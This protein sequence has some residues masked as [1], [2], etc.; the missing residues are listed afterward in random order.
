MSLLPY[1]CAQIL[2]L[3]PYFYSSPILSSFPYL[4]FS[5]PI[6]VNYFSP[7]V[8]NDHKGSIFRQVKIINV[9]RWGKNHFPKFGSI[10]NTCQRYLTWFDPRT[11]FF[12]PRLKG[13]NDHVE[14]NTYSSFSRSNTRIATSQT[15]HM[16]PLDQ[17]SIEAIVVPYK[18]QIHFIFMNE[19]IRHEE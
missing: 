2:I 12:T 14:L 3:S 17:V 15:C 4:C 19:P 6:F 10:Q 8:F 9:N 1:L 11:S 16:L 7:F 18:H 13:Y 5:P